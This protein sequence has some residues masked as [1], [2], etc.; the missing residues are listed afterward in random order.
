MIKMIGSRVKIKLAK[1][2]KTFVKNRIINIL[3]SFF[4]ACVLDCKKQMKPHLSFSNYIT[5]KYP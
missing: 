4:I 5:L 3:F 1:K 2:K